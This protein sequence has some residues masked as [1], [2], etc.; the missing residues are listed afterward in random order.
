M[1]SDC[2]SQQRQ[3]LLQLARLY[4]T[5]P[6]H[7]FIGRA[8]AGGALRLTCD[9][10]INSGS[11]AAR[12]AYLWDH[13]VMG[14]PLLPAA[15]M[16]ELTLAAGHVL[17]GGSYGD[18]QQQLLAICSMAINAPIVM[19]SAAAA[20]AQLLVSVTLD[21]S[22]G[23]LTLTHSSMAPDEEEPSMAAVT[24]T[25]N[26]T[27]HVC[28]VQPPR[29]A[30]AGAAATAARLPRLLPQLQR[31]AVKAVLRAAAADGPLG[32]AAAAS[33]GGAV[34]MVQAVDGRWDASAYLTSPQ[35]VDSAFHLSVVAPGC[36]AKIPVAV[37]AFSGPAGGL[38]PATGPLAAFT[39]APAHA[40]GRAGS[41]DTSSFYLAAAGG[42]PPGAAVA[43]A[44][45]LVVVSGLQTKLVAKSRLQQQAAEAAAAEAA[46]AAA[47]SSEPSQQVAYEL[48][49]L[50]SDPASGGFGGCCWW[51]WR[52]VCLRGVRGR[53]L[54]STLFY[55][56]RLEEY[57]VLFR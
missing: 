57:T 43:P 46:A 7:P 18:A 6:V 26:A 47:A 10:G 1:P 39:T 16:L 3:Q 38:A 45:M 37:A 19:P 33:D 25:V 54:K 13:Q 49:W 15:A 34:G 5:P 2:L 8:S 21:A 14:R 53:H 20:G 50:A 48:D 56:D 29:Q 42:V 24:E 35:Q 36:P 51:L 52:C 23:Q 31:Q 27:A 30:A 41:T 22:S 4:V 44:G 9:M 11:S 17:L 55:S 12:L 28:V 32:A 40:A